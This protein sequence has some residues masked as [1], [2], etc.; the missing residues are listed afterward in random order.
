MQLGEAENEV[1][2]VEQPADTEV[3]EVVETPEGDGEPGGE[4]EED[5]VQIGTEEPPASE[6]K[7][8]PSWVKG[9]RE[10][11]KQLAKENAELKARMGVQAPAKPQLPARPTLESCKFDE[12]QYQAAMDGWYAKK[13]EV[14]AFEADQQKAVERAQAEQQAVRDGYEQSKRALKV[15]D[16]QEAEAEAAAQLS[17]VQQGILLKGVANPGL[18]VYALGKNPK[19]LADLASIKDPV[20][21]AVA[22]GKLETEVK[23]T[24]RTSTKPAPESRVRGA[25]GSPAPTSATLDRLEAEAAKTG[26]RSKVIA[27][28]R[29]LK[30]QGK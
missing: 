8:A 9:L 28:K 7:E 12:E 4:D 21:F 25:S 20:K 16:F 1:L 2:E 29:T 11:H 30:A 3:E 27:Y 23:V 24:K 22:L 6:D 14:E 10:R 19:A 5:V 18:I 13:R 17:Q 15:K 26:D